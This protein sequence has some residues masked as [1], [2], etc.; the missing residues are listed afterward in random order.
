MLARRDGSTLAVMASLDQQTIFGVLSLGG[1]A[2]VLRSL[3]ALRDEIKRTVLESDDFRE[4]VEEIGDGLHQ[5]ESFRGR[6]RAIVEEACIGPIKA[7]IKTLEAVA[8]I[9]ETTAIPRERIDA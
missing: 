7:R 6:V 1:L 9:P 3:G 4:R 8:K 2:L 5:S